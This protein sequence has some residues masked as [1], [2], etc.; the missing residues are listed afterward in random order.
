[1]S[2]E[3]KEQQTDV[4]PEGGD[5]AAS[6]DAAKTKKANKPKKVKEPKPPKAPKGK[7]EKKGGIPWVLV[8]I[9]VALVAALVLA[10]TLPPTH[11]LLMKSPLGPLIARFT[12]ESPKGLAAGA[13][14]TSDPAAD[15]KRL[16]DQVAGDKKAAADKDAQ[17]SQLQSQVSQIQATPPAT[18]ATPAPKPTAT[19]ISDDVKR[20]AAYWA[21]MD[22][23]K[24]AAIIKLLPDDY[25]K[26]VFSQMPAD[27][28]ADI[29]SEMPPKTAARLTADAE[30][31][32][33]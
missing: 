9:P 15:V 10:F 17:I 27:A 3:S 14:P 29:M 18:A 8:L 30:P 22:P 32:T 6:D 12:H 19:V 21:G 28:V 1:V 31:E 13:K 4:P 11:A 5:E 7:S 25:V 24:A 33:K 20:A 2:D 23:D 26:A 16:S